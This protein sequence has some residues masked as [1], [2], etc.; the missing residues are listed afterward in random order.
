MKF[1]IITLGCKVNAYESQYYA[2]Q[3]E[4]LGYEQVSP[5]QPCDICII[6][7]CTVTNTAAS[8]SRQKIHYAKRMNPNALCVVVGCFVQFANEEERKAL[9]ADLVIGAKQKNELVKLIQQ[10]L[11]EHEKIA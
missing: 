7:T 8:K 5:E 2:G 10:A 11:N 1:S 6:N 4:E 9:D 3:L